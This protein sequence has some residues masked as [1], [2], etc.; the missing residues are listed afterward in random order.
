[1][2]KVLIADDEPKIR[3]GLKQWIEESPFDFQVVAEARNGREALEYTI[4]DSPE[5]FFVDI[6]MPMMGGFDFIS[7]VKKFSPT[8]I[9]VI[10]TGYDNFEYAHKA[11]KF[12]VFDYLLK[13]VSKGEFNRLLRKIAE[14]LG[15]DGVEASSENS[16]A[17]SCIIRSVKAYIDN[18]FD[19][20]QLDLSHVAQI[21][22]VNKS[23][24]SKLM[25]QELGKSF[26]EYLTDI[27]LDKA[28]Q[29]LENDHAK[30]TMYNVST[31]VGYTS[32]HYFSRVFKKAY[33]MSPLEYR[34]RP[35]RP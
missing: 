13:P 34:N 9:M 20:S 30:V 28:R 5:L 12:Q 1:M 35:N 19:D 4:R 32:Q 17:Y 3:K 27:R 6:N 11:I 7:Q 8:S 26:V 29:I 16:V 2:F 22:N 14:T 21:F 10:I 23:Y 31:R 24:I 25:K 33:G 15:A 18:H